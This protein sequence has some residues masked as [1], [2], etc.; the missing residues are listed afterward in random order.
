VREVF[1]RL[2]VDAT[3]PPPWRVTGKGTAT[4]VAFPSDADRSVRLRSDSGGEV[5]TAC[6]PFG[7]LAASPTL[8]L[9]IDLLL[10]DMPSHLALLVELRSG[11]VTMASFAID[12]RGT[13]RSAGL[14]GS[15]ATAELVTGSWYHLAVDL[16]NAERSISW[17]LEGTDGLV[18]GPTDAAS[19][20]SAIGSLDTICIS[21]PAG[22]PDGATL[23]DNVLAHE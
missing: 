6:R 2:A 19:L 21:S 11:A 5:V 8:Q 22:A 23:V 1:D 9:E 14:N 18:A 10:E 13:F 16:N 17:R 4:V 7:T 20:T 15:A 12:G 3:L